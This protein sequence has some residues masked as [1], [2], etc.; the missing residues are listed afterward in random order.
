M[1]R[2]PFFRSSQRGF[3]LVELMVAITVGLILTAAVSA[4]FISNKQTY[5]T[6]DDLAR[7]QENARF[8]LQLLSREIRMAGYKDVDSIQSFTSPVLEGA[9]DTGYNKSDTL[10]VRFF[11]EDNTA[12]TAADGSVVDC[13]GNAIRRDTLA[14]DTF[15][16]AVDPSTG[17]PT[18]Y[19]NGAPL[20][21][22]VESFQILY[23][24]DTDADGAVNRFQPAGVVNMDNVKS[25][26]ISLVMRTEKQVATQTDTKAYNHFGE[27]Y[28]PSN[29]APAND[30]GAVFTPATPDKRIRRIFITTV[31]LRNRLN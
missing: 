1:R 13:Q 8:T 25:V 18:L 19:C 31:G 9:N 26:L 17:E 20:F 12:G 2:A 23:G 14:T 21:S 10:T 22:G 4:L 28:A 30:A 27:A 6:Q 15:S 24:E 16:I 11:G 7:L 29:A 3:S 5:R